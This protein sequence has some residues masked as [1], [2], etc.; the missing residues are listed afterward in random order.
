MIGESITFKGVY[1]S[2]VTKNTLTD[3]ALIP[4]TKLVVAPPPFKS[5]YANLEGMSGELDMSAVNGLNFGN[6]R[7]T[8]QFKLQPGVSGKDFDTVRFDMIDFLH[9]GKFDI[10]LST[11]SS[12]C[13]YQGRIM[14]D[15]WRSTNTGEYITLSYILEPFR[16]DP[17]TEID[18]TYTLSGS[19]KTKTVSCTLTRMPSMPFIRVTP[20][21]GT[22]TITYTPCV[23]DGSTAY[24]TT[25]TITSAGDVDTS[26]MIM[27][28]SVSGSG[29]S[30]QKS[31]VAQI[32]FSVTT[33]CTIK[34]KYIGG[35]F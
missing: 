30:E 26:D 14:V 29:M 9:G 33:S 34:F 18:A 7:G 16:F 35:R 20:I 27:Y 12:N 4:L 11:D 17:T 8:W 10:T 25:K 2:S 22:L 6:R 3:W 19:N 32:T 13:Y 23:A 5:N 21:S 31:G 24:Q 15:D 1:D 28:K